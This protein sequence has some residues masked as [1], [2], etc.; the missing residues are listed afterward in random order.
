M[1]KRFSVLKKQPLNTTGRHLQKAPARVQVIPN[2][3]SLPLFRKAQHKVYY[4][5]GTKSSDSLVSCKHCDM[6]ASID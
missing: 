5:F 3:G 6:C 1:D 4:C 2:S